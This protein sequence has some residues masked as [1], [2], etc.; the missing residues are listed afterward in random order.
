MRPFL[1]LATALALA[2]TA[3]RAAE[4]QRFASGAARVSL[5]ELYTSEGCSSCPPAEKWLGTLRDD[6]RL[7]KTFVPVAW[8]VNYWDK[9]GWPDRFAS[10]EATQREYA[11]ADAWGSGTVY[12]PCFVRDG[13]EWR[14]SGGKI[15]AA[16][17]AAAGVLSASYDGAVLRAEFAPAKAKTGEKFDIHTALLGG[18]IVSKV[19]AGENRGET[20]KHEFVALA[21][22]HGAPG[23][24]IA[25]PKKE[26]S[27]VT[28]YAL[29]VWVTRRGELTPLQA[30]GGWME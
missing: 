7:W 23:A 18:G 14:M 4:S 17:G 5:L 9:L 22:T 11:Y 25:L 26:I 27:G 24:D 15:E 13:E 3:V 19:G 6:A 12:T 10:R 20:L 2:V 1:F 28:R 29:A 30:T 16:N 8:H 21:Q